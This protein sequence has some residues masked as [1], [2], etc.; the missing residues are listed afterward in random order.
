M[1]SVKKRFGK[2]QE[3]ISEIFFKNRAIILS[4]E[5]ILKEIFVSLPPVKSRRLYCAL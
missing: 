5:F 1:R 4:F 2:N 3:E